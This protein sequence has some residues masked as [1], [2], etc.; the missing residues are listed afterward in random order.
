M[1]QQETP[2]TRWQTTM[3]GPRWD[4]YHQRFNDLVASGSDLAGE[5]RLLDAM[6]PRRADVLDAGCGTGRVANA[7]H[8]LE[9]R[10]VG[11]DR[12]AGLVA[13]AREWYPGTAYIVSDLLALTPKV[14]RAAGA[15]E[16]FDLIALPGNVLVFVAPGT[17]RA[18]LANLLRLLKPRGR[19]VAGFATD[20]EYT[21]DQLDRDA[22]ALGLITE[23][24]FSTW[25]LE[26]WG[27][28]AD[29]AVSVLRAAADR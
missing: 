18:V 9:H 10:V 17:E 22:A 28:D 1:T 14:L 12:D 27:P 29:W 24:R 21:V 4:S 20:R 23:H 25:D 26:P 6:L 3:V 11:V 8:R 19:I 2:P 16:Q 13:A 15:P 5:A 7:L